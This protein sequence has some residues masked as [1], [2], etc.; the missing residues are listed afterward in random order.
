MLMEMAKTK[1]TTAWI[2]PLA[3]LLPSIILIWRKRSRYR[4]N[5]RPQ[6]YDAETIRKLV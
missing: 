1:L 5:K 6:Y 4:R 3:F 2:I